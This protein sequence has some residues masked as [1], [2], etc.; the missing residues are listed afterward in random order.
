MGLTHQQVD[1]DDMVFDGDKVFTYPC[2]CGSAFVL[3][4]ADLSED[5]DNV[6][7]QCQTCSLVIKVLYTMQQ[8][9][10]C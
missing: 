5:A 6:L 4:E 1:L 2:R 7:M 8:D 9:D 10:G 3:T